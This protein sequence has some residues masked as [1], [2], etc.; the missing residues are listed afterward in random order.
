MGDALQGAGPRGECWVSLPALGLSGCERWAG[1]CTA[2]PPPPPPLFP[3]GAREGGERTLLPATVASSRSPCTEL[4]PSQRA[5]LIGP[6]MCCCIYGEGFPLFITGPGEGVTQQRAPA[7]HLRPAGRVA[8]WAAA[9][10]PFPRRRDSI[11]HIP[12]PLGLGHSPWVG[13][14]PPF[15]Q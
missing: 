9:I 5:V 12:S 14:Q 4:A 13:L 3:P 2:P 8:P 11:V 1:S 7:G 15:L 6:L 10:P